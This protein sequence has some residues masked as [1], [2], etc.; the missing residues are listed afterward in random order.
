MSYTTSV[1]LNVHTTL[2]LLKH[3]EDF[4]HGSR[5]SSGSDVEKGEDEDYDE[6]TSAGLEEWHGFQGTEF[7]G[8]SP[9]GELHPSSSSN[10][11]PID[12]QSTPGMSKPPFR[13]T[14]LDP[15]TLQKLHAMSRLISERNLRMVQGQRAMPS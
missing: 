14:V 12:V 10:S 8:A 9:D 7:D 2:R 3:L 6:S 15:V 11:L 5:L 1:R 4:S 13:D